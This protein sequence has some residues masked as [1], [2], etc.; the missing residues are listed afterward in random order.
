[1][2]IYRNTITNSFGLSFYYY[3]SSILYFFFLL[4]STFVHYSVTC[5]TKCESLLNIKHAQLDFLNQHFFFQTA[6][7]PLNREKFF[8][9]VSISM[10]VDAES[11]EWCDT[12]PNTAVPSLIVQTIKIVIKSKKLELDELKKKVFNL[13]FSHR[14]RS[15]SLFL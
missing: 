8:F 13:K 6:S 3:F 7:E 12:I 4:S 1:M 2:E 14:M 15:E 10:F 9:L 11:N 5:H